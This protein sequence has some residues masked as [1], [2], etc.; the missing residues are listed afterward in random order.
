[1]DSSDAA[2]APAPP[3]EEKRT[4]RRCNETKVVKP[5]TWVYRPDRKKQYLAYGTVCLACEKARKAEYEKR[6]DQIVAELAPPKPNS[7]EKPEEARKTLT[8]ASK[9][10]VAQ[11]LKAGS[12]VIN[13]Y[14]PAV[15]ARMLEYL[16]DPTSEHHTWALEF[17]AQRIMPR[18]LYEELGGA[19]AGIGSLQDKRPQF[20]IQVL[21]AQPAAAE[22]RV[23]SQTGEVETVEV[24]PAQPQLTERS[25]S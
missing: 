16:E 9:L 5:E 1:M 10:D 6:R 15:L 14:A 22:G 3:P 2:N 4:C 8:A 13:E 17:F 11:A 20:V 7:K 19:A 25:E 21:P 12:R 18:K 23:F 24:L